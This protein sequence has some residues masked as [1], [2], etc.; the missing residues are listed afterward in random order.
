MMV[1]D[2]EGWV[3]T[4]NA[5]IGSWGARDLNSDL[6]V[7]TGGRDWTESVIGVGGTRVG[8]VEFSDQSG[9]A[10]G[11]RRG[12]QAGS[13]GRITLPV[14]LTMING[15]ERLGSRDWGHGFLLQ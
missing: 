14:G 12:K 3:R 13:V 5:V 8:A 15:M 11:A 1:F 10:G 7:S 2:V 6:G 9:V 4:G